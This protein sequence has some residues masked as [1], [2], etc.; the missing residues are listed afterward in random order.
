MG[1]FDW[2]TKD[3]NN[4]VEERSVYASTH[5]QGAIYSLF[6]QET[7]ITEEEAMRIPSVVFCVE[8][9]SGS[10]AQLPVYLYKEND[11][12]EVERVWDDRRVFLLNHEPNEMLN[13]Y[14]FKKKMVKDY[15]FYGASYT[16]MVKERNN[17]LEMHP[18]NMRNVQVTK[19]VKDGY[20][21][22]ADIKLMT[23]GHDGQGMERVFKPYEMV[24]VLRDSE[25]GITSRGILEEGSKTLQLALNEVEYSSN[26]LKN[27]ALPI[28]VL[29]TANKISEIAM[30]RLKSG[31]ESLYSGARNAGKTVILEEGLEYNPISLRPNDLEMVESK[32][33]TISDIS[34]LFNVPESMLN[35]DANKYA[36]NEQNNLHFLQFT[37]APILI[38]IES[39]LDKSLLLEDEKREGYY[40][41]F[42]TNEILRT[43][44]REKI[45]ATTEA[46]SKGLWSLNEARARID[47]PKLD[48][49]YFIWSLGNVLFNPKTNEIIVPNMQ[50]SADL[51]QPLNNTSTKL[52]DLKQTAGRTKTKNETKEGVNDE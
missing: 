35:A 24:T 8:L 7:G 30:K 28:G 23:Y 4:E 31:W 33:I 25:D 3:K 43:T 38:A 22:S 48:E 45:E 51:D 5:T 1:F 27:G 11:K 37:L 47:L 15:L 40:F 26:I 13:G 46:L 32:K 16:K 50:G 52:D 14:N 9:I 10:I 12:G 49:D 6:S 18:F 20:K 34:R 44:E 2:F 42:D 21:Y 17:V 19:Y 39:A 36:S 41:R 29:Q